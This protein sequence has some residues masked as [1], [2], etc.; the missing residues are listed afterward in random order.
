MANKAYCPGCDASLSRIRE[1]FDDGQPCPNCGLPYEA[2]M[3]VEA[4]RARGADEKLVERALAAEKRAGEMEAELRDLRG[5]LSE[6]RGV[7]NR[8]PTK[9]GVHWD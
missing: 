5:R 7:A 1:A 3:A 9:P 6:I 4:A 8:E 2:A